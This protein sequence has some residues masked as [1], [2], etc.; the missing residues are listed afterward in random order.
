MN[1]IYEKWSLFELSLSG[2]ESEDAF[3]EVELKACF[4]NGNREIS[5]NGFYDGAGCYKI[6]LMPDTCGI[7]TYET[8]SSCPSLDGITGSFD[9]CAAKVEHGPVRVKNQFHFAYSDGTPY[10]P[11]GTTCYAWVHQPQ[12]MQQLT[13]KTLSN[14]PFNKM[15]MCVFPKYYDYN[16]KEPA[17]YPYE[18][19]PEAGFNFKRPNT[20]FYRH[21]E[22][23]T[24]DLKK[25]GI[26]CDL[27]LFHPYDKWGFSCMGEEN[28]DFYLSYIV[29]RLSAFGN[30]WWSLA[31]EYDLL[32]QASIKG[33]GS[34]AKKPSDWDRFAE[35]V[36]Q[37]DPYGHLLSVHNCLKMFDFT[38]L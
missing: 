17:L 31:N 18:G 37:N 1:K 13:E 25:M 29:S 24:L 26:E 6:R 28:D 21:L 10:Y 15:R 2:P 3:T 11:L 34:T 7:W 38:K 9:C 35:I 8:S 30:V 22:Q 27:I 33:D 19:S 5:V 36:A 14:A 20:A 16:K 12:A 23:R 4:K 32:E